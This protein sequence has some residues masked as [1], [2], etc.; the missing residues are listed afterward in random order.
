[1]FIVRKRRSVREATFLVEMSRVGEDDVMSKCRCFSES[2]EDG[3]RGDGEKGR[4]KRVLVVSEQSEKTW[5]EKKAI[6]GGYVGG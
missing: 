3:R 2:V 4:G 1:L 5:E 6:F